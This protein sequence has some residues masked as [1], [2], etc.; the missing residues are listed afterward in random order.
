M[1]TTHTILTIASGT[2]VLGFFVGRASVAVPER[3]LMQERPAHRE[4]IVPYWPVKTVDDRGTLQVM[5]APEQMQLEGV[6]LRGVYLPQPGEPLYED[7]LASLAGMVEGSAI[8]LDF[9]GPLVK[10][11]GSGR[12]LAYVWANIGGTD[13]CLNVELVRL[14][15]ARYV[16]SDAGSLDKDLQYAERKAREAG[17]GIWASD[18]PP[19]EGG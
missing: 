1:P 13:F 6:R 10:R 9:D 14:G 2:L 3:R 5:Y 8:A 15:M 11:D 19:S 18:T 12:L 4:T 16:E 7:A 17:R